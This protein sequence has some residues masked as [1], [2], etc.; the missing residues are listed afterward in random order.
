MARHRAGPVTV[1][2]ALRRLVAEGLVEARPGRGSFVAEREWD[3]FHSPKNLASALVVEA[4]ER[5]GSLIT[6]RNAAAGWD[7]RIDNRR[8]F[9]YVLD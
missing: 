2:R 8:G 1:Q 9:G 3:Q 7:G 5:S 4:A 6:A